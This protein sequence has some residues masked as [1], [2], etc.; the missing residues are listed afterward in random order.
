[1]TGVSSGRGSRSAREKRDFRCIPPRRRR[2]ATAVSRPLR[3]KLRGRRIDD[4]TG[5][6]ARVEPR[7]SLIYTV[8]LARQ[9]RRSGVLKDGQSPP[10]K[11]PEEIRSQPAA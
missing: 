4:V 3:V 8:V 5:G 9:D 1:M 2:S 7:P 11:V 10:H 6:N